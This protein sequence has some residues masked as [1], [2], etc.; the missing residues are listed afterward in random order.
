MHGTEHNSRPQPSG[1]PSVHSQAPPRGAVSPPHSYSSLELGSDEGS[2][3]QVQQ[4]PN[5]VLATPTWVSRIPMSAEFRRGCRINP[6]GPWQVCP[7]LFPRILTTAL[8]RVG[9]NLAASDPSWALRD[10]VP[11]GAIVPILVTKA[12]TPA[13]SGVPAHQGWGAPC[14]TR[15]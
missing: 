14:F 8:D 15:L 3:Q 7:V 13:A 5:S 2:A 12:S 4:V 6:P 1:R 10:Y 11:E 9:H